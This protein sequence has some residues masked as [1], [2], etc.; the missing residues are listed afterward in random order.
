MRCFNLGVICFTYKYRR[1]EQ[2]QFKDAVSETK[3]DSAHFKDWSI[4]DFKDGYQ[5]GPNYP[6]QLDYI[7]FFYLRGGGAEFLVHLGD[8]FKDGHLYR[9]GAGQQTGKKKPKLFH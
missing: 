5:D 3:Q 9:I 7:F 6:K 8:H 2:L 1:S 4:S